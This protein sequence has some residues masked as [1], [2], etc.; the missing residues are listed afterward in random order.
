M[1]RISTNDFTCQY[2]KG[3]HFRCSDITGQYVWYAILKAGSSVK[4]NGHHF[5]PDDTMEFLAMGPLPSFS[6]WEC[7]DGVFFLYAGIDAISYEA[8]PDDESE[9]E[10]APK[11]QKR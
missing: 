4:I 11:R 8:P 5:Q 2:N 3:V 1:Y 10:I 9:N 6:V 7:D